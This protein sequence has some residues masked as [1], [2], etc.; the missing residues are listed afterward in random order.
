[1]YFVKKRQESI[2][3]KIMKHEEQKKHCITYQPFASFPRRRN[4]K[5]KQQLKFILMSSPKLYSF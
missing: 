3:K 5:N 1:M 4:M 2:E